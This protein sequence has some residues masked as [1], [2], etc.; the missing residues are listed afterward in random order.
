M[1]MTMLTVMEQQRWNCWTEWLA[2]DVSR[3]LKAEKLYKADFGYFVQLH[4]VG[5]LRTY[6]GDFALTVYYSEGIVTVCVAPLTPFLLTDDILRARWLK[7]DEKRYLTKRI[8]VDRM[9]KDKGPFQ[10]RY[11]RQAFGDWKVWA[12]GFTF[13]AGG[14]TTYG[15]SFALPTI[16]KQLGYTSAV[17]QLMTVPVYFAAAS[18]VSERPFTIGTRHILNLLV[19][20]DSDH[21][22]V[23]R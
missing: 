13:F 3:G 5:L 23:L 14:C 9:G 7:E 8:R 15:M 4:H 10:W 18:L 20:T 21:R 16:I 17:A 22:D 12:H 6:V 11:A 1:N 2:M 19:F